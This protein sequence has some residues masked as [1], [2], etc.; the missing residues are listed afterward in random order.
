MSVRMNLDLPSMDDTDRQL[1]FQDSLHST[2]RL[3]KG[4]KR[5]KKKK[6]KKQL[7]SPKTQSCFYLHPHSGIIPPATFTFHIINYLFK[8]GIRTNME[9][10]HL[11]QTGNVR[12]KSQV[13][14]W[15]CKRTH[16]LTIFGADFR[17]MCAYLWDTFI[18]QIALGLNKYVSKP[19]LS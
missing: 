18:F 14:V 9:G 15:Q 8:N 17:M 16:G 11:R 2:F 19:S 13:A 7:W 10:T 12:L 3:Y 5:G 4:N 6:K 1:A